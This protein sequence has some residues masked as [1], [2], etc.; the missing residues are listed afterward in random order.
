MSKFLGNFL[1]I[2]IFM[3]LMT[4]TVS[5][6][7]ACPSPAT[8]V[9]TWSA[10]AGSTYNNHT[11]L[12]QS[13][14]AD[15]YRI[16]NPV[17]GQINLSIQ[18]NTSNRAMTVYLYSD[19][20]CSS[21]SLI[22]LNI[23]GGTTRTATVD[24]ASGVSYYLY[25]VGS[26][27]NQ[28]TSY[29]LNANKPIKGHSLLHQNPFS[30]VF[31]NGGLKLFGDF[32]STG[33]S[34]VCVNNNG[35]C[36]NNYTGY[37][38]DANVMYKNDE[39]MTL[40]SA[41]STLTLPANIAGDNIEWA[42]LYWQGHIAGQNASDYTSSAM[43]QNRGNVTFRLP[44]GT[45]QNI[46]ADNIWYHD[47]WG[48][49]TGNGGGYRSFYQG[50]KD[51][52]SLVKSHL[53]NGISQ[54]FTVGNIKANNGLDWYSYFYLG[55]NAEFNGFKIGFW[56]NWSLIVIY[57]YSPDSLPS[58]AKVKNVNVFNG[59]DAMVPMPATG[60]ETF[61][62]EI[63]ISGFLTPK[64]NSVNA[65][66]LFYASGGEKKIERDAFYIQNANTSYAYQTVSNALNPA[67]NP[68]NGSVSINGTAV[69]NAISYYPGMDLDTYDVSN[70]MTN[71]QTST[72]LKLEATFSNNNGDQ[73]TPG[74][75]AF[76]TDLYTPSFCY[77][78]GY[79]QNGLPF[80]EENNG[81][82]MPYV[83]GTLTST[84]DINV[85]LYIRNQENSDVNAS[86]V[87]LNI[88]DINTTQA[89]YTRNSVAVTYPDQ[90]TPTA[91]SDAAWPLSVSDSNINNIPLGDIGGTKYAYIYYGLQPQQ[92]GTIHLPINGTFS[93]DLVIPLADGSTLTMPYSSTIGGAGLPM[94]SANN[95]GYTPEW[96]IFSMVEAGLYDGNAITPRYYD[97]TTQVAKRPGNFRIASFDPENLDTPQS[98]ST[99][100]AVELIDAGQFHDVDAACR[101]PSSAVTPRIW[102]TFE[103]NVSQ[104]NFN[105]TTIN[106]AITNGLVSDV[107]TGKPVTLANAKE[108]F[109]TATPNAAFRVTFN[110]LADEN[111]SLIHIVPTT[112]GIRIDNFSNIHQV[113]PHC[114][115]NVINPNNNT[116]T[117]DT[118]VACSDNGN[119][120]TFKDIAI[121]MECLYGANTN[122][123]CSRDNFAIRPESYTVMLKDMNQTNHAETQLFALG[124]TGVITPNTGRINI[125]SGYD[126]KYDINATNH[127]DNGSTPGYTRYFGTGGSD[128][129]ISLVWEPSSAKTGCNDTQSKPQSF[130]LINGIAAVDGNLS[131]VGEYRLNII[132]KTWTAVDWNTSQQTHQ[133]GA[134]FLSGAECVQNSADVPI[135]AN[136]IGLN[137]TAL[138]NPVG[139]DISSTHDNNENGLKYR[140]YL[141]TF[142]PYKFDLSTITF[143]VGTVPRGISTGGND[144]VYMADISRN[145]SM[146][147]SLRTTGNI[148]AAGYNNVITTNFVRNCYAKDLNV[149]LVSDN[150]LSVVD[151]TYQVRFMDFN[152]TG[153]LTYDSNA[154]D[155]NTSSLTMKLTTI[156]EQH[157]V[158]DT[159]GSL[160]MI[161]RLNY[162]RN[163]TIPMSPKLAML[164]D[165]NVDCN[166]S[167]NCTMQADLSASHIAT[168]NQA[169]DFNVTYVYG[170]IIPRDVRVF[171]DV[172]F[173]A[174]SWYEV[175]NAP[176]VA[177]TQ[178]VPSRNGANWYTNQLHNDA[179][180][181]DGNVTYL[182]SYSTGWTATNVAGPAV[183]GVETYNFTHVGTGNIPYTR[184][185]HIDT[186][187]WLWYGVNALNYADPS[188]ANMDCLTHPCFN[189][190]VVPAVG[191]G[192]SATGTDL[193]TDKANKGT[194]EKAT[195]GSVTYDYTPATR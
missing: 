59:F 106:N 87:L 189:I 121:C 2:C 116:L 164:T 122:V 77:D 137:G 15:Y 40:N 133:T 51:V 125:A 8:L 17:G 1:R 130:N 169:M 13:D 41:T 89:V 102:M 124:Y 43:I 127:I 60:Y 180:D 174:N 31:P 54:A 47:F 96:G 36:N 157:Y 161:S 83:S 48:D 61:N 138:T 92:M 182:Q 120:S 32:T 84:A 63:P 141:L 163:V 74:A 78:Y 86:N 148:N 80:T 142:N 52:T 107:I 14:D 144:F 172:D 95:F 30:P 12:V 159:A 146:D 3:L 23:S 18:N 90:Y 185:A 22:T 57:K 91:K 145:D 81:T 193:R 29:T 103:N 35:Q 183:S 16:D 175:Y 131:Q 114:R 150:N 72:S 111:D 165:L 69:N 147:M 139:C 4:T 42:G 151:T 192:G 166:V 162:D 66:M 132:D 184:K 136:V 34:V 135:Q 179:N 154:T 27:S 73:S 19:S 110:T 100:V 171:G 6:G 101:E 33:A 28:D 177:G 156:P 37:L 93:Y 143:G 128:Y 112:H 104:I 82:V 188:G 9:G 105:E 178:L 88:T 113:Y 186:D 181:G 108:F 176:I 46:T 153:G 97:L 191:R 152:S 119:N 11:G 123:L 64:S 58:G 129:N 149:T 49:G 187:S 118:A 99:M 170:R 168:G 25:L 126:Y 56:G 45:T 67:N 39:A 117:N 190:N 53:V 194:T 7:A 109:K 65:K 98:V 10:T 26:A 62:I 76:S 24:V 85:S 173:T 68:F 115:Q 75:I 140:D 50:Y 79:E 21:T 155:I 44:D 5:W 167:A 195:S 71:N 158:K 38:Y 94:C 20:G 160:P 134:H 55:E 70:Y